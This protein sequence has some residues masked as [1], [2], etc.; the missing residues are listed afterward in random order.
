MQERMEEEPTNNATQGEEPVPFANAD[1]QPLMGAHFSGFAGFP[2][3]VAHAPVDY[4][5]LLRQHQV[6][7]GNI[8][9]NS[10]TLSIIHSLIHLLIYSFRVHMIFK[11]II[12]PM[13]IYC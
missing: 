11:T 10:L 8:H 4:A 5:S 1:P 9:L 3:I 6:S 2:S 12:L 13:L 7:I